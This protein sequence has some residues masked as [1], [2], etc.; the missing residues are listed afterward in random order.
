MNL[1]SLPERGRLRNGGPI[2]KVH[3][4]QVV[5]THLALTEGTYIWLSWV[6]E[7]DQST[8]GRRAAEIP[9]PGTASD[10]P[11]N[12][13]IASHVLIFVRQIVDDGVDPA[14]HK[15]PAG[16]VLTRDTAIAST[17]PRRNFEVA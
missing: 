6:L 13:A 17:L 4:M 1:S 14:C 15:S 5:V 7:Q 16:T 11:K 3:I 8:A 9:T 2:E 12:I 10:I